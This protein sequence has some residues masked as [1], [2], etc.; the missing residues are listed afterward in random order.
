MQEQ[1]ANQTDKTMSRISE[2]AKKALIRVRLDVDIDL[3]KS[4]D[5][6][7][8]NPNQKEQ[9][10]SQRVLRLLQQSLSEEHSMILNDIG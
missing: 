8:L 4:L 10:E 9:E 6:A 2:E 5:V 7:A 3:R 1:F